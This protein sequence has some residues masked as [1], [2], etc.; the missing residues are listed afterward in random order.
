MKDILKDV[1]KIYVGEAVNLAESSEKS[2]QKEIFEEAQK[3]LHYCGK[4]EYL[5][6]VAALPY[7]FLKQMETGLVKSVVVGSGNAA[8]STYAVAYQLKNTADAFHFKLEDLLALVT[9]TLEE[10]K[11]QDKGAVTDVVK[12]YAVR[13]LKTMGYE[14][15]LSRKKER[16][17]D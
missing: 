13:L 15:K 1:S 12:N 6:N 8:S 5:A 9:F 17:N 16:K 4:R 2:V 3:F 11:W 7:D 10:T 14:V